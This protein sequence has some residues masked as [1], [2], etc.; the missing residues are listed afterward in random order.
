MI[1][2]FPKQ[3][4][5]RAILTYIIALAIVSM[6]FFRHAMQL[7]YIVLGLAFVCGFFFLTSVCSK[8]WKDVPERY[9][10]RYL[11]LW[12]LAIRLVWV[13]A[14][15]YYYIDW[16]GIPFEY[17]TED[18]LGY[19][20]S[21]VWF[22][23]QH[24]SMAMDYFFGPQASGISD[25]GY[26]FYLTLLYKLFGPIIIIPR[27][28]KSF[29][30]AYTCVLV[31]RIANRT[32]GQEVGRMAGIMCMF[33]PNLIIY[34]GYHLKEIEMIFLEVA[35]LNSMDK[36]LRDRKIT[37]WT[38]AL[39]VILAG[40]LFFFRTVL[41][42]AAV[43]AAAAGILIASTPSMKGGW[44]RTVLIL[45]GILCLVAVSSGT[46]MTEVEMLWE[47]KDDNVVKKRAEQTI[48]G[49]QWATYATGTV[50]APMVVIL[51]FSTMVN[52]DQQYAQQTKHGGN[53]IRNFMG[54]FAL[55]AI[56]EAIR[57][58]RLREFAM[59][60]AFVFAYL[61]I[62]SV[63]GFSNSERFLLPGLPV[64]IMMWAYGVSELRQKP[65]MIMAGWCFLVV[66]MEYAWA[67]FKLGSRGLFY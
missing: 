19:H 50:M 62:I 26:P 63:S 2:Y 40:S 18:A 4:A 24:W 21:A 57:Q 13:V 58:K 64:L 45:F 30:G 37:F 35:F 25:V 9:Y 20:E 5:G 17:A 8:E 22:A 42:I 44:R 41:G 39:T 10:V 31:F 67:F 14:S 32:F 38:I 3:I 28:I 23:S 46:A 11:F 34:C 56:F 16:T 43:I 33:M 29:L 51:P 53:F 15:Y 49:N 60:G 66:V 12:A 59:L 52:V 65:Y 55:L 6:F 7:G 27:I 47:Q 48:R 54:F 61:G 36:L 1:P